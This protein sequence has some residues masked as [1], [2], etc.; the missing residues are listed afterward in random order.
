[1]KLNALLMC[2]EHES[3]RVLV[4]A[5]VIWADDTGRAGI[6]FNDL[7]PNARRQ[8]KAWLTKRSSKRPTRA[9]V[10]ENPRHDPRVSKSV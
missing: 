10:R 3:M 5:L 1:M 4:S 8:L 6:L 7:A 2:R 9:A